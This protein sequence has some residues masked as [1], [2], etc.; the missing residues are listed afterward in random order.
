MELRHK[1]LQ[2]A[3]G[4]P[5][6]RVCS[7]VSAV[8]SSLRPTTVQKRAAACRPS[9]GWDKLCAN[10]VLSSHHAH[11]TQLSQG[12]CCWRVASVMKRRVFRYIPT[13]QCQGVAGPSSR[14]N[15]AVRVHGG[16]FSTK[17]VVSPNAWRARTKQDAGQL[18]AYSHLI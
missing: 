9:S 1:I 15:Y 8:A 3:P 14:N 2:E 17:Q 6:E 12:K 7:L 4:S 10:N 5:R 16:F 13:P 11:E 18:S